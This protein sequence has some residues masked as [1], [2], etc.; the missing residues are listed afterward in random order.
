MLKVHQIQY[1]IWPGVIKWILKYYHIIIIHIMSNSNDLSKE[2][3]YMASNTDFCKMLGE[4]ATERVIK[5]SI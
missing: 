4:S 1:F 3:A 5:Y 2:L